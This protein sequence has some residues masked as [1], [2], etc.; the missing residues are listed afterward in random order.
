MKCSLS[1][2]RNE[3]DG[4]GIGWYRITSQRRCPI[5]MFRADEFDADALRNGEADSINWQCGVVWIQLS[6]LSANFQN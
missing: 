1:I 2:I 5:Q 6:R 4:G 3:N